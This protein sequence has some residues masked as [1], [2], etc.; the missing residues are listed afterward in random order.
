[1]GWTVAELE[2]TRSVE[3]HPGEP[4]EKESAA[5]HIVAVPAFAAAEGVAG[6]VAAEGVADEPVEHQIDPRLLASAGPFRVLE[7][8]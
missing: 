2:P 7:Q 1:M 3:E 8:S 4:A 6:T 5:E